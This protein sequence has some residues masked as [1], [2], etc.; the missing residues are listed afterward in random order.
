MSEPGEDMREVRMPAETFRELAG[1]I[2]IVR[3]RQ[4]SMRY[5]V[6]TFDND[7]AANRSAMMAMLATANTDEVYFLR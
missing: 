2:D 7:A 5:V 3:V 4:C 1:H 6:V